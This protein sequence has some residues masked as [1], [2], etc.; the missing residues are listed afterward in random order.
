[1]DK[2]PILSMGYGRTDVAV[3]SIHPW[4]FNTPTSYWSQASAMVKYIAAKEG[5]LEKL[6]GKKLAL[7]YHNSP[8]GKEPIPTLE[9]LSKKYGFELELLAVDHPGQEQ[10]STWLRVRQSKPD[11]IFLW[12]WGVMNQV[13]IKEAAGINFPMDRMVGVWWSGTEVDVV[14]VGDRARGYLAA[15]FH[16]PGRAFKVHEDIKKFLYDRSKGATTYDKTGEVLYNRALVNAMITAEAIRYA[17]KKYGKK[18]TGEHVREGLENL[19]LTQARLAEIGFGGLM[20]P[21]RVT[22]DDHEGNGP[23][24]IQ[25]WDGKQWKIISDWIE[26][27]RDVVRPMMEASAKKFAD[28]NKVTPRNCASPS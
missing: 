16:A 4:A 27:M 14:P 8:Y 21:I 6:K 13:A 23:I 1:V 10:K 5:G 3:G 2:I 24:L 18:P 11:W 15:T 25:Q 20:P 7:V 9:V 22:C 17:V 12:G 28:E 26:P 19:N